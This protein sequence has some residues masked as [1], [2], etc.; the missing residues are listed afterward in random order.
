MFGAYAS[1][2]VD[3]VA[4]VWLQIFLFLCR[5]GKTEG[6]TKTYPS[7]VFLTDHLA[8]PVAMPLE[9][10]ATGEFATFGTRSK[11]VV[12]GA[13]AVS[14]YRTWD[15]VYMLGVPFCMMPTSHH[16]SEWLDCLIM[17]FKGPHGGVAVP[18]YCI[19]DAPASGMDPFSRAAV[20]TEEDH[21]RYDKDL[22]QRYI[23]DV[24]ITMSRVLPA[25]LHFDEETADMTDMFVPVLC[26]GLRVVETA[27]YSSVRIVPCCKSWFCMGTNSFTDVKQAC[28][29]GC[30]QGKDASWSVK[31]MMVLEDDKGN[32]VDA[33]FEGHYCTE[34]L[35]GFIRRERAGIAEAPS[36]EEVFNATVPWK[37]KRIWV[38]GWGRP[39]SKT[40]VAIHVVRFGVSD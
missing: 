21:A 18:A 33:L 20:P 35:L 29:A 36:E 14:R 34:R 7:M 19:S 1:P 13:T 32:T 23:L 30:G 6:E 22:L 26:R 25:R 39:Q 40:D 15:G 24:G 37:Q 8:G 16:G 4:D 28:P 17:D 12:A 2:C 5:I 31:A 10:G 3:C 9:V 27:S 38:V 11:I